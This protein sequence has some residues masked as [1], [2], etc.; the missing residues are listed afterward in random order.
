[1]KNVGFGEL[2]KSKKG[3]VILK[4]KQNQYV[5]EFEYNN[6]LLIQQSFDLSEVIKGDYELYFVLA[7]S[8]TTSAIRGIRFANI[9]M[10]NEELNASKMTNISIK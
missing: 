3:F 8:F 2:F 1:M 6:E 9:N 5:F 10:Y 7:D 4:N